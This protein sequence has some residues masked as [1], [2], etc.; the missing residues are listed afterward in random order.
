MITSVDRDDLKDG[1]AKHFQAC[2]QQIR[3]HCPNIKI[4]ILVPDFR[5][6]HQKALECLAVSP[7]DVFNHNIET[8]ESLYRQARPGSSYQHSLKLLETFKEQHPDIPTKSGIMVGLGETMPQIIE[9]LNDLRNHRVDM[10]TIGQYLSP[11][12]H[13]LPVHK[14]YSPDEFDEI[15]SLAKKLKFSHVASGFM[16]RSSYHADLQAEK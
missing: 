10:I 12:A 1:G 9:T 15:G 16:V 6:R 2:I 4:E 14:Y 11:S 13:H 3:K 8:T 7:P 5:G